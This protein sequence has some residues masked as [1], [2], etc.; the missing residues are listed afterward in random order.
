M[1]TALSCL[2]FFPSRHCCPAYDHIIIPRVTLLR[3]YLYAA[4]SHCHAVYVIPVAG[5]SLSAGQVRIASKHIRTHKVPTW[6]AANPQTSSWHLSISG[7]FSSDISGM[8]VVV[9]HKYRFI[10][11]GCAVIAIP[12]HSSSV[13]SMYAV[14]KSYVFGL[15]SRKQGLFFTL[16]QRSVLTPCTAD[17]WHPDILISI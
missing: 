13:P 8:T 14:K 7:Y 6:D 15:K 12:H 1:A 17:D 11:W 16:L 5:C 3:E 9:R 2:H 4:A 10:T